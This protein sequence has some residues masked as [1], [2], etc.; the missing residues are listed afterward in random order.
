MPY[1]SVEA[2]WEGLLFPD[3]ERHRQ[4]SRL[5]GLEVRSSGLDAEASDTS[6]YAGRTIRVGTTDH[7]ELS[8]T[9]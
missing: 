9:T 1:A 2:F 6:V 5:Y 4:I 3:A 7:Q 8:F